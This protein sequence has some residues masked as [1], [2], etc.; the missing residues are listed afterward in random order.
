MTAAQ[1][2]ADLEDEAEPETD[3]G[4]TESANVP[5]DAGAASD[6]SR[7]RDDASN[8]WPTDAT[9]AS[10]ATDAVSAPLEGGENQ[11]E[12][13][14]NIDDCAS[15]PCQRGGPCTDG[16]SG[17]TCAC[18]SGS[19]GA[20]CEL[21]LC[22]ETTILSRAGLEAAKLC[23]EIRGKL[24]ISSAGLGSILA[25]DLP[26]LTRVTGDLVISALAGAERTPLLET[27]TLARLQRVEGML[28][29]A[30][31]LPGS[32]REL[33]LPALTSIG[34]TQGAIASLLLQQTETTV[35]ALPVLSTVN[36]SVEIRHL[37]SLCTLKLPAIT[38]VTGRVLLFNLV[39]VPAATL[40][41][42]RD[43]A[44]G[45]VTETFVGCC[46]LDNIGCSEFTGAARDMYCGC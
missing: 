14:S 6:A 29:V 12:A 17:F 11:A 23:A 38:R 19:T 4:D 15:N 34:T 44:L 26:H 2:D 27:I 43:A 36:G 42:L 18:P 28:S 46:S 25:S 20:R 13:D 7:A 31:N 10:L 39:N 40:Q 9:H 24:S 35:L 33:H 21:E 37:P 1:P 32:V 16:P 41:P 3:A 45:A 5:L 22:G 8:G 30:G